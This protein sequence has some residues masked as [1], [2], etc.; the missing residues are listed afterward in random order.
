MLTKTQKKRTTVINSIIFFWVFIWDKTESEIDCWL[1]YRLK[2]RNHSAIHC[3]KI[4]KRF[5]W[6]W[7]WIIQYKQEHPEKKLLLSNPKWSDSLN[8]LVFCSIL[9]KLFYDTLI[10]NE[11]GKEYYGPLHTPQCDKP[12]HL[13]NRRGHAWV[14]LCFQ[15][16]FKSTINHN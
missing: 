8:S 4:V 15:P 16:V 11:K 14:I 12:C 3:W 1:V 7:N 13:H 2:T 10:S 5:T 9:F 6:G